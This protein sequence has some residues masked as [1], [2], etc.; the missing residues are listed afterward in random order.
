MLAHQTHPEAALDAR[1]LVQELTEVRND[2]VD[3]AE[4]PVGVLFADG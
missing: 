3:V 2:P 1:L 4:L